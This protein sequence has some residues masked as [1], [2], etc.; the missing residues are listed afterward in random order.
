[1]KKNFVLNALGVACLAVLCS[2]G[3]SKQEEAPKPEAT[4]AVAEN[5]PADQKNTVVAMNEGQDDANLTDEEKA[6][7]LAAEEAAKKA[8]EETATPP[9]DDQTAKAAQPA[10]KA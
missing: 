2:C 3:D 8:A 1:M 10:D 9:A 6:A 7:K 5:Q 4:V